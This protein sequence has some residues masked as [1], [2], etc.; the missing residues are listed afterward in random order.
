[1]PDAAGSTPVPDA[2][3]ITQHVQAAVDRFRGKG[4][5]LLFDTDAA[6]WAQRLPTPYLAEVL[7]RR[8][9]FNYRW[10]GD[11]LT[12]IVNPTGTA[13][14]TGY[15]TPVSANLGLDQR[16]ALLYKAANFNASTVTPL[17]LPAAP[18]PKNLAAS[19]AAGALKLT[20]GRP[21]R[22]ADPTDP[23]TAP[24]GY[25]AFFG[26][27]ADT[28]G[29]GVGSLPP[30]LYFRVADPE[31]PQFNVP[32]APAPTPRVVYVAVAAHNGPLVG[33]RS[34]VASASIPAG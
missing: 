23:D 20:F 12:Q 34:N 19:Y 17:P 13:P 5:A 16:L 18:V 25:V 28:V 8:G 26:A 6:Y 10:S 2:A 15:C 22:P 24:E 30:R 27:T 31:H 7:A 9:S 21:A 11:M 4:F 29:Q 3:T 32:V 14:S 33:P 1:M